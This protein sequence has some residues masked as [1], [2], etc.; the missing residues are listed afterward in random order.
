MSKICENCV[1]KILTIIQGK[2][3]CYIN[4]LVNL[5]TSDENFNSVPPR[6]NLKF[7]QA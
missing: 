2:E 4:G 3:K 1:P 7:Y 5:L 6:K